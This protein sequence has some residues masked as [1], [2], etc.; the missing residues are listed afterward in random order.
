MIH[1]H[2]GCDG[3]ML[4]GLRSRYVQQYLSSSRSVN[5]AFKEFPW[6]KDARIS[7][8]HHV[9]LPAPNH[10]HWLDLDMDLAVESIDGDKNFKLGGAVPAGC[11]TRGFYVIPRPP[12]RRHGKRSIMT[13]K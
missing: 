13:L 8:L 6:F 3:E 12:E 7:E 10:L 9:E 2:Q 5:V 11:R 1:V 4:S